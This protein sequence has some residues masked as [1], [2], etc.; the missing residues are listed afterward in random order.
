VLLVVIAIIAILASL[1]LPALKQARDRVNII[2]DL[3]V[4]EELMTPGISMFWGCGLA[5]AERIL[6]EQFDQFREPPPWWWNTTCF[7]LHSIWQI[8]AGFDKA[9]DAVD[10]LMDECGVNGFGLL[11]HDVPWS[12]RDIDIESMRA[13]P[14]MGG[15]DFLKRVVGRFREKGGHVFTW[16]TR[17]AFYPL[18]DY[19]ESWAIRGADG[20]PMRLEPKNAHA[21]CVRLSGNA[22]APRR[23]VLPTA[24]A[25]LMNSLSRRMAAKDGFWCP[26]I[27]RA[28]H[29]W[30][31]SLTAASSKVIVWPMVLSLS[32]RL[33]APG[34]C[35]GGWLVV[36]GRGFAW[37]SLSTSSRSAT[38]PRPRRAYA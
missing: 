3:P 24:S 30:S 28:A 4:G 10:I 17:T 15:E 36:A 34:R 33:P 37:G 2:K 8:N 29:I 7:W 38:A 22:V 1:L 9:L 23:S 16:M 27:W 5:E 32:C 21:G 19:R 18:G 26:C 25:C 35:R 11:A 31:V 14:S 12:G 13:C 20:A 6:A